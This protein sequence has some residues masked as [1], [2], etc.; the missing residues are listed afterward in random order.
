[1]LLHLTDFKTSREDIPITAY[2]N[3]IY[4]KIYLKK[5]TLQ[6]YIFAC[7]LDRTCASLCVPPLSLCWCRHLVNSRRLLISSSLTPPP[8]LVMVASRLLW[9]RG[10]LWW[11]W[12]N[13]HKCVSR[14]RFWFKEMVSVGACMFEWVMLIFAR[15][16]CVCVCVSHI[17]ALFSLSLTWSS[18]RAYKLF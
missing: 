3:L 17:K 15:S 10:R 1:M 13:L 5:K 7:E 9:R 18:L 4:L 11:V 2:W 6:V 8:N 12:A 16:K 14:N